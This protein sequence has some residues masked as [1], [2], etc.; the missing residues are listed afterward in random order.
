MQLA[1]LAAASDRL[2]AM[3]ERADVDIF[4]VASRACPADRA[5]RQE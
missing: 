2:A 3:A 1:H 5:D 4:P